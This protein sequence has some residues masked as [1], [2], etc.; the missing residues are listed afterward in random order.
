M[1]KLNNIENG[2]IGTSLPNLPSSVTSTVRVSSGNVILTGKVFL[3]CASRTPIAVTRARACLS[4]SLQ[5]LSFNNIRVWGNLLLISEK[6]IKHKRTSSQC[7]AC[8]TSWTFL[9]G[10]PVRRSTFTF[11]MYMYIYNYHTYIIHVY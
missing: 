1:L 11:F 4:S 7:R 2:N 3:A 10:L 6:P 9:Q 8:L 5:S